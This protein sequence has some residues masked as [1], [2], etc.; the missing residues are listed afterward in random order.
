MNRRTAALMIGLSALVM[1]AKVN[2]TQAQ[3]TSG[4]LTIAIID[5]PLLMQDSDA[6]K[7]ARAQIEMIRIQYQQEIKGKQ[8]AISEGPQD[9]TR[10][11]VYASPSS[12][13][14]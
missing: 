3:D 10:F 12:S 1:L 11:P 8:E 2:I 6:A 4:A 5:V 13:H 14:S 7:S 9:Q